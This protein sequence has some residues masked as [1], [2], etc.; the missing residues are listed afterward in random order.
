[1]KKVFLGI[2]F[3]TSVAMAQKIGRLAPEPDPIQFP[4]NSWGVDIMFGEGGFGLGTF[5]RKNY[6]EEITGFIDFSISESKD[7]RE[8]E[9][10]DI[11][12]NSFTLGK[13]NRVFIFPLNFGV[14]YRLF[15]RTITDKLRPYVSLGV[16][17]TLV[18][19]TPYK[20]E[21]FKAFSF[22]QSQIALG[23]YV[24]FGANF[25]LSK[26]NL[27]GIN[28]RYNIIHLFGD[29][30]ENMTDRFRT[31]LQHFYISLNLGIMY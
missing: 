26:S 28:F 1:M 17:P 6:T 21:F 29:G 31:N 20:Y 13:E 14:Q 19:T 4:E 2:I 3:L 11:F 25:G 24:G 30:V 5:F 15:S 8:M 22:T 23:G 10:V 7:E 12:G 18:L 16:G 9:Y 27:V